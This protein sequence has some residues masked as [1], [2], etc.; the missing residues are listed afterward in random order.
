MTE[1]MS[2]PPVRDVV[3]G[4]IAT[5]GASGR[6]TIEAICLAIAPVLCW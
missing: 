1:T 4:P 5:K 6:G 3:M 2:I